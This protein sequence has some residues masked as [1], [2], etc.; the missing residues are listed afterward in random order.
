MAE[1]EWN[2]WSLGMGSIGRPIANMEAMI[3]SVDHGTELGTGEVGEL[4]VRGPNMFQGY[5]SNEAAT[6]ESITPDGWYKTGDVGYVDKDGLLFITDRIKELIKYNGFQVA[7]AGMLCSK[8]MIRKAVL[9][10][11][12]R[13]GGCPYFPS[14]S[15]G[16]R[17]DWN[18]PKKSRDRSTTSICRP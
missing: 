10:R 7:P 16:R 2:E 17:R 9:T 18:L 11:S 13:T 12:C 4:W 5:L 14:Q 8:T 6:K 15:Q 3:V 1:Q